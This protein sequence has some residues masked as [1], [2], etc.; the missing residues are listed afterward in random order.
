MSWLKGIREEGNIMV[1]SGVNFLGNVYGVG[2]GGAEKFIGRT[3]YQDY[4][5][6]SNN[7]SGDHAR[8]AK[9]TLQA[10]LDLCED[11]RGD[12]IVVGG[13][14]AELVSEPMEVTKE[15]IT[16]AAAVFGIAPG[17]QRWSGGYQATDASAMASSPILTLSK[18]TRLAGLAFGAYDN[19]DPGG[20]AA[21]RGAA[22]LINGDGA[23]VTGD[24]CHI[25]GCHFRNPFTSTTMLYNFSSQGN[26]IEHN[27]FD[28]WGK[29]ACGYGFGAGSITQ[30]GE[31]I[32]RYNYFYDCD[33]GIRH[34]TGAPP[35]GWIH[36][37]HFM[38]CA[39]DC[40]DTNGGSGVV[41]VTDNWY[42]GANT[43]V[44]E[45]T[46]TTGKIGTWCFSGNHYLES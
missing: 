45:T 30:V 20:S 31:F 35:Q 34:Y 28:G 36:G 42:D 1:K 15:G 26:I 23:T 7:N 29:T 9:K 46:L 44:Y 38:D 25:V 43:A 19:T 2:G 24:Y 39:T 37:N 14:Y 12:K 8:A 22:V 27:V 41:S 16:I 40:I 3:F 5:N 17:F 32:V 33:K 21:P 13:G 11:K 10:C 4:T 18:P 6:G